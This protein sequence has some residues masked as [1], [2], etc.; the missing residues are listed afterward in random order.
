MMGR[1][2][3][4]DVEMFKFQ[5]VVADL[6]RHLADPETEDIRWWIK[7]VELHDEVC[8]WEARDLLQ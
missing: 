6:N 8:E 7:L 1:K 4:L 3:S 2:G 5:T